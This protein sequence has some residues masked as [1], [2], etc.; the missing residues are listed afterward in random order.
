MTWTMGKR[1]FLDFVLVVIILAAPSL[2]ISET[3]P[4]PANGEDVHHRFVQQRAAEAGKAKSEAERERL[5]KLQAEKK[6]IEDAIQ[7]ESKVTPAKAGERGAER[8]RILSDQGFKIRKKKRELKVVNASLARG[9]SEIARL[10]TEEFK[11]YSD[12]LKTVVSLQTQE[13]AM[14]RYKDQVFTDYIEGKIPKPEATEKLALVT[15]RLKEIEVA[16]KAEAAAST[17]GPAIDARDYLKGLEE[18]IASVETYKSHLEGLSTLRETLAAKE[19]MIGTL[20]ESVTALRS[21]LTSVRAELASA[22]QSARTKEEKIV[23]LNKELEGYR[24]SAAEVSQEVE[25]LQ[26][27]LATTKTNLVEANAVIS[28]AEEKFKTI[29]N[30]SDAKLGLFRDFKTEELMWDPKLARERA[31]QKTPGKPLY[32]DGR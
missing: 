5:Q 18:Q 1:Q 31:R 32:P 19:A 14:Y 8:Q 16:A 12:F 4:L 9:A 10:E 13:V 3:Q 25:R 29:Q 2:A 6:A 27:E 23:V 7:E 26:A 20:N 21:E 22:E 24:A 28:D 11:K 30:K 17:E 15:Q